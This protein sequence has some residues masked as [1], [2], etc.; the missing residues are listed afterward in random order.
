MLLIL[1]IVHTG[2]VYQL[3]FSSYKDLSS[4]TIAL[5]S[6]L[7]PVFA[8]IFAVVILGEPFGIYQIVGGTLIL[9]STMISNK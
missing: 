1:G 2:I 9:G 7:D 8:I 5:Y 6:Y 3:Y 4:T